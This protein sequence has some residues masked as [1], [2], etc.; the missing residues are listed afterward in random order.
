MRGPYVPYAGNPILTQRDLDPHRAN[1]ITSAGHADLVQTKQGS[2]WAVFLA[3]RPYSADLRHYNIGRETF[4]LPVRW[5]KGWPII[6]SS[7]KPIPFTV[8]KPKLPADPA[9]AVKLNGDFSYTEEFDDPKL[10]MSWIG[11]RTP[12]A[13]FYRLDGGAL[14]LESGAALGD[15]SGVPAFIGR[16]QQH[17]IATVS[18]TLN[19]APIKNGD[20]AGL[21]AFQNDRAFLFFGVTEIDGKPAVALYVRKNATEDTLIAS[22]PIA[23]GPVTLTMRADC[24][25]AAFDY[26]AGGKTVTLKAGVDISFLSTASAGGFVGTVI[27][28]YAYA[29]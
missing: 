18:T 21:A 27:G 25:A 13:P 29:P 22:A 9:V 17:H 4:M 24:G 7:G 23:G 16:R 11:I 15:K 12:K 26:I 8:N 28:P 5:R 10:A 19:F 2:W 6:L 3:T 1:P 20:R 14:V